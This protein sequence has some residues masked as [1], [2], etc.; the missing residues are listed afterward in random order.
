MNNIMDDMNNNLQKKI[1]NLKNDIVSQY[2]KAFNQFNEMEKIIKQ[3]F[4]KYFNSSK[5][6]ISTFY[7]KLLESTLNMQIET[8]SNSLNDLYDLVNLGNGMLLDISVLSKFKNK[9]EYKSIETYLEKTKNEI[10]EILKRNSKDSEF[11]LIYKIYENKN[12][13][14]QKYC[15]YINECISPLKEMQNN[16]EKYIEDNNNKMSKVLAINLDINTLDEN[17]DYFKSMNNNIYAK[18]KENTNIIYIF[19]YYS[20]LI[21]SHH[22][23]NITFNS[24][25]YSLFDKEE[26]CIYISGGIPNDDINYNHYDDSLIKISIEFVKNN[27]NELNKEE[28]YSNN[29]IHYKSKNSNNIFN[30]GEYNFEVTQL[31][32]LLQGRCSHCMIRSLKDRNMLINIGG[33]N[34]KST[35]VYNLEC[36]KSANINDLPVICINPTSIEYN[37]CIYLFSNTEFGLNSVYCLDM[38]KFENF[39]WISIQFN[40]NAGGLKRGMNIIEINDSLYLFG[41]YD[42][43]KEY[44]DIY[45]VSFNE[46]YLDINFC[47]NLS[48]NHDCSF[49]SNAIIENKNQENKNEV[50]ILMDVM[51]TINEINFT[52]GKN[53][54]YEFN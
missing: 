6:I 37:G 3:N 15:Q 38:N 39:A 36:N 30:Y 27:N 8:F 4:E 1:I 43:S 26:N 12:N 49:N 53:N 17:S 14:Y 45:K 19:N 31:N 9:D 13:Y 34:T 40:I 23:D 2:Q 18:I 33:K 25:C 28:I 42:Q 20:K 44:S 54:I 47:D 51:D 48:L 52:T 10:I 11:D 22:I 46:E 50:I 24:K 5:K 16:L 35:E 7:N 32:K 21:S 41:G 29:I